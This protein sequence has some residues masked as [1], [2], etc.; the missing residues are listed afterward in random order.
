MKV[1]VAAKKGVPVKSEYDI[2]IVAEMKKT[3]K[4]LISSDE[5]L[6]DC[7]IIKMDLAK[8][9]KGGTLPKEAI[10]CFAVVCDGDKFVLSDGV[11]IVAKR[12][13]VAE[14]SAA[15]DGIETVVRAVLY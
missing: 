9:E 6:S 4:G 12:K 1:Y 15:P 5:K 13:V 8:L 2:F 14:D 3:V 10:K 11:I 7:Q